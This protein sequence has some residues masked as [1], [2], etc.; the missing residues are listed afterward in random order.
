MAEKDIIDLSRSMRYDGD[1]IVRAMGDIKAFI[2]YLMGEAKE[3]LTVSANE[4]AN[5]F[6]TID[7]F[8]HDVTYIKNKG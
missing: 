6:D 5:V 7:Y 2:M 1:D 3:G 8:T 4:V